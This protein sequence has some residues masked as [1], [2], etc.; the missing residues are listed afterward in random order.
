MTPSTTT[1]LPPP[2]AVLFDLDGTLVDTV[3]NRVI[4]WLEALAERDI[5]ARRDH[6][7]ALIGAD[8]RH[9]ARE[10]ATAAGRALSDG[11]AGEL[12]RRS[13]EIYGEL[14]TDPRALPGV[15]SLLREL[16]RRGIPWAIATS[17]RPEQVARSV[18]ALGLDSQPA[19]IDGGQVQ[20]A[21]PEP[22]LM[23]LGA[24]RLGVEPA[25][26]WCV[27]DATWDMRSATSA[28][29]IPIG[30]TSGAVDADALT[31]AGARLV[32]AT[33]DELVPYLGGHRQRG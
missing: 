27:G 10:V 28:G 25:A 8:G 23:L 33:L 7:E 11:E 29:M 14:N 6:V 2:A 20:R 22:D 15:A 9:V 5:P 18:A 32:V 12:D 21:K 17:S 3:E 31:G 30:V 16:I 1:T 26:C 19:V 24:R 13:G 4:S